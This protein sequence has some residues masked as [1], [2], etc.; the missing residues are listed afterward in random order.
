ATA[1]GMEKGAQDMA[2]L[3]TRASAQSVKVG[4]ASEET[5]GQ[6]NAV[7]EDGEILAQAISA[8]GGE[9]AQSSA[10]AAKAVEKAAATSARIHDLAAV[11]GEIGKVTD[12]I[13]A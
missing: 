12:L 11:S 10:I 13:S 1:G 3:S 9:A 4:A 2:A 8:I 7:A 5:A 6:V